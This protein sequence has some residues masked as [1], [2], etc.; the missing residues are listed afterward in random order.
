MAVSKI[1]NVK[2]LFFDMDNTIINTRDGDN[3]ALVKVL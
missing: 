2:A 3:E 1:M